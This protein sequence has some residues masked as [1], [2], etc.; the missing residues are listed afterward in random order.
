MK[1][2]HAILIQVGLIL[3]VGFSPRLKLTEVEQTAIITAA[4]VAAG[5]SANKTSTSNPDGT[6]A[7]LPWVRLPKVPRPP[8]TAKYLGQKGVNLHDEGGKGGQ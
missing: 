6:G 3:L 8:K 7:G 4:A 5:F 1:R 2:T